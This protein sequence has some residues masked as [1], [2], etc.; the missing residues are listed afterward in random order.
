MR[1][2]GDRSPVGRDAPAAAHVTRKKHHRSAYARRVRAFWIATGCFVV[3]ACLYVYLGTSGSLP[4]STTRHGVGTG[5]K[6]SLV[7]SERDVM[8]LDL[9]T[10]QV[11]KQ[12]TLPTLTNLI[13]SAVQLGG[14]YAALLAQIVAAQEQDDGGRAL[15]ELDVSDHHISS[16][17]DALRRAADVSYTKLKAMLLG[18]ASAELHMAPT[19]LVRTMHGWILGSV[20]LYSAV[21]PEY[22]LLEDSTP[23]HAVSLVRSVNLLSWSPRVHALPPAETAASG[24]AVVGYDVFNWSGGAA[25]RRGL[26][27]DVSLLKRFCESSFSAWPAVARRVAATYEELIA[28]H[29][30]YAPLRLHYAIAFSFL[31]LDTAADASGRAEPLGEHT[32]KALGVLRRDREKLRG[33]H[34]HV[35]AT[36]TSVLALLEVFLTPVGLRTA[37]HDEQ[38][39]A[40][41]HELRDCAAARTTLLEPTAWPGDVFPGEHRPPLLRAEQL[42]HLLMKAQVVLG[43]DHAALQPFR[44]CV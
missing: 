44:A 40:A 8:A 17:G 35:D 5:K 30:A 31:A 26:L 39:T 7:L 15:R 38:L 28:L 16:V 20:Y 22:Y 4:V 36:H 42:S 3:C 11:A 18:E 21:L 25:C 12:A 14:V 43:D 24:P 41:L 13:K 29:P 34:T 19:S 27:G 1:R 32:T 33:T 10:S 37:E 23:N 6:N 9:A 2:R